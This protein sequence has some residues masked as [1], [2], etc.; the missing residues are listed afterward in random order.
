MYDQAPVSGTKA[1]DRTAEDEERLYCTACGQ[2]VTAGRWRISVQDDHEH[3]FFNPAGVIF[4][5]GCFKEAPGAVPVGPSSG[6]FPWFRGTRWQVA[7]CAGCRRHMGWLFTGNGAPPA[8]FGLI[9]PNLSPR[10]P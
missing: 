1:E 8:F 9:L 4:R 2:E 10:K 5:I 3:T 6:Q 7:L